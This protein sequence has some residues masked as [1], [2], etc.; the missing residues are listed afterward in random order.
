MVV[1][2]VTVGMIVMPNEPAAEVQVAP[3]MPKDGCAAIDP[4][5]LVAVAPEI[6]GMMVSTERSCGA[7]GCRPS[8]GWRD[9]DRQ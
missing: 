6:V 8:D 1:A 3:V 5:A 7:C 2:P 9:G 4:A